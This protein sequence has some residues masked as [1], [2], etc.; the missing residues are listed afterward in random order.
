MGLPECD[1]KTP[2]HV[3][4]RRKPSILPCPD[5]VCLQPFKRGATQIHV[6]SAGASKTLAVGYH[7]Y[8]L[9]FIEHTPVQFFGRLI[10]SSTLDSE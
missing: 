3:G 5:D 1:E 4:W 8:R 10:A 7:D 6:R 9:W 2:C